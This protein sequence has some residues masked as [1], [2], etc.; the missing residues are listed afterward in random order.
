[1]HLMGA[2]RAQ[3]YSILFY[4]I[5]QHTAYRNKNYFDFKTRSNEFIG[6]TPV[7]LVPISFP[8]SLSNNLKKKTVYCI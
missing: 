4:N 1:M 5:T 3:N 2:F 8:T 7:S 6:T